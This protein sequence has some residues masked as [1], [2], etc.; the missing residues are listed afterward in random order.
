[1]QLTSPVLSVLGWEAWFLIMSTPVTMDVLFY[2]SDFI[3]EELAQ[4]EALAADTKRRVRA[5]S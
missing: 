2:V 3:I 1:V 5:A 4:N